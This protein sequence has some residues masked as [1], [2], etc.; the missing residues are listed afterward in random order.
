[1]SGNRPKVRFFRGPELLAT[2]KISSRTPFAQ[3]AENAGIDI[4]TNCTS[5][6]CGTCLVRLIDGLVELPEP[7]PPG[8][9]QYLVDRG[10]I[11][12]CCLAPDDDCDIDIIPPL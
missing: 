7:L 1:M 5:G 4:P 2:V 6:N 8:L 11:L 12:S 3:I 10:G 9:D